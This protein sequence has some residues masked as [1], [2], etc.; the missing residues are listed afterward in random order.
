MPEIKCD[1][2]VNPLDPNSAE[3]LQEMEERIRRETHPE[4]LV[5]AE[6]LH[7]ESATAFLK[8]RPLSA[9]ILAILEQIRS[10]F[11]HGTAEPALSDIMVVL[12]L[13]YS[14]TDENEIVDLAFNGMLKRAAVR[15]SFTVDVKQMNLLKEQVPALLEELVGTA[16]V[17]TSEDGKKK[18]GT[19]SS[20]IRMS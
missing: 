18:S 7:D 12:F 11:L 5:T 15:W 19:G 2:M 1:K 4:N 8:H 13:L 9:G 14:D 16:E 20:T 10:P 6:D 17:Y 3:K